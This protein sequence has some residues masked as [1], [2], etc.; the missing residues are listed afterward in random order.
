MNNAA[1]AWKELVA[2]SNAAIM[3]AVIGVRSGLNK[4]AVFD[5]AAQSARNLR[6]PGSEM[7][8]NRTTNPGKTNQTTNLR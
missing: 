8:K 6:A 3:M 4:H 7:N 2:V 5:A 1:L